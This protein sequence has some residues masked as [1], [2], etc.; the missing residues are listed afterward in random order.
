MLN[1][2]FFLAFFKVNKVH[3]H[4]P[5]FQTSKSLRTTPYSMLIVCGYLNKFLATM[6]AIAS[7]N[8]Q[9][10]DGWCAFI[11]HMSTKKQSQKS[12]NTPFT[13]KIP[14]FCKLYHCHLSSKLPDES[15]TRQMLTTVLS[16]NAEKIRHSNKKPLTTHHS[17][18]YTWVTLPF[19]FP[20]PAT[21]SFSTMGLLL[22]SQKTSLCTN[23]IKISKPL[24]RLRLWM[25]PWKQERGTAVLQYDVK[26]EQ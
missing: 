12:F 8:L 16:L 17:H 3:S 1:L 2:H 24:C 10:H 6:L 23:F 5:C 4:Q 21:D 15:A 7:P 20:L 22:D 18:W 19:I 11:H 13:V 9:Q 14:C 25:R 26:E